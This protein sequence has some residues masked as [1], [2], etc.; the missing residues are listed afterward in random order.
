[1]WYLHTTKQASIPI[2]RICNVGCHIA[3]I[4]IR[5][6]WNLV[7]FKESKH[8]LF[9][10]NLS[11]VIMSSYGELYIEIFFVAFNPK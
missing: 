5:I 2:T 6:A 11:A 4:L 9:E 8:Q 3:N 1:M 10:M 7:F